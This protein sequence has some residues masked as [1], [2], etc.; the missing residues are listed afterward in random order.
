MVE[1][2]KDSELKEAYKFILFHTESL[3]IMAAELEPYIKK[4]GDNM[5]L[6]ESLKKEPKSM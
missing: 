4:K 3:K 5:F 1:Q 6:D 2:R